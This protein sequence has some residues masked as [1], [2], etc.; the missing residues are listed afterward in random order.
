MNNQQL[1]QTA[2][3]KSFFKPLM[4]NYNNQ[5]F[6]FC[7]DS[8]DCFIFA[9][10]SNCKFAPYILSKQQIKDYINSAVYDVKR[11][12]SLNKEFE[13]FRNYFEENIYIPEDTPSIQSLRLW[14]NLTSVCRYAAQKK[15]VIANLMPVNLNETILEMENNYREAIKKI[16][17]CEKD[18][19]DSVEIALIRDFVELYEEIQKKF[20]WFDIIYFRNKIRLKKYLREALNFIKADGKIPID[21]DISHK[22]SAYQHRY[23][24]SYREKYRSNM[25]LLI[26]K[27][28]NMSH[29]ESLLNLVELYLNNK[30]IFLKEFKDFCNQ[31]KAPNL[32]DILAIKQSGQTMF[33]EFAKL[34]YLEGVRKALEIN[35]LEEISIP[36]NPKLSS[37]CPN[38]EIGKIRNIVE[39]SKQ[40]DFAKTKT[41]NI[42]LNA[43]N[44]YKQSKQQIDKILIDYIGIPSSHNKNFQKFDTKV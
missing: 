31:R 22:F 21:F 25:L 9:D 3:E 30:K 44:N 11:C 23:F 43:L 37:I 35:F 40:V 7:R 26:S 29:S 5:D 39:E 20:H 33:N 12:S 42:Y 32:T 41:G 38:E 24:R 19:L 6:A 27:I 8:S 17:V 14:L 34:C 15:K 2:I 36:Q 18:N 10:K 13:I 4:K 16:E 28:Q 1:L